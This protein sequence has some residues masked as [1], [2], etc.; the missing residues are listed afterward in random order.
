M[1]ER[2]STNKI[3]RIH[4]RL[5]GVAWFS[6]RTSLILALAGLVGLVFI[7]SSS[8]ISDTFV[9]SA[10]VQKGKKPPPPPPPTNFAGPTNLRI[11][12]S[13][14][15]TIVLAWNPSPDPRSFIYTVRFSGGLNQYLPKTQTSTVW[16]DRLELGK[17]YSFV[18]YAVDTA[19]NQSTNSNTVTITLPS[20]PTPFTAPEVN[21]TD[22]GVR[23][24][25]LA[26]LAGG[27][28]PHIRYWIYRDGVLLNP[29]PT[30]NLADTYYL[31]SPATTYLFRVQ[32][33]DKTTLLSPPTDVT[34]TTKPSNPNDVTPPT[35]PANLSA[36]SFDGDREW[37]VSW[38]PS[39]DDFDAQS[40]IRY[41]LYVNG[42]LSD[43]LVGKTH[44][45]TV[46]VEHGT[47]TITVIA[48][49]TAGNQ[50]TPATITV[51]L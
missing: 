50:S 19:A 4:Q 45:Q 5:L 2:I 33:R 23:H 39:V 17:T 1:R 14:S 8:S 41:D 20:T 22:V 46:Y 34:V 47:N 12:E 6:A 21:V 48:T 27:G 32:A 9:V 24:I 35:A 44:V 15:S 29:Q 7:A 13:T 43:I 25:S 37:S 36:V 18:V 10:A 31:L 49:D 51:V 38:N 11:T 30:A 28:T 40:V 16:V 26:W 3:R 42:V